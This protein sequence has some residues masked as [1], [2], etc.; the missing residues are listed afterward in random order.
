MK[1]PEA[2]AHWLRVQRDGKGLCG[3]RARLRFYRSLCQCLS[4]FAHW[5]TT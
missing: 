4:P 2:S 3:D 5:W 1:N